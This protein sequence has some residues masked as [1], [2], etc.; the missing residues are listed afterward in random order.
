MQEVLKFGRGGTRPGA[1]RPRVSIDFKL[2]PGRQSQ[3]RDLKSLYPGYTDEDIL[4]LAL[5]LLHDSKVK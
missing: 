2:H 3:L 1:G 5:R 4:A